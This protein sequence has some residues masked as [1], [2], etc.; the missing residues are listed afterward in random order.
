M[1]HTGGRQLL[2]PLSAKSMCACCQENLTGITWGTLTPGSFVQG[3]EAYRAEVSTPT[4]TPTDLPAM[5]LGFHQSLLVKS[6]PSIS[7][8]FYPSW[9]T[10]YAGPK[11]GDTSVWAFR[12]L[13]P[14]EARLPCP[15]GEVRTDSA[16]HVS[17]TVPNS[18]CWLPS[19]FRV[20]SK[21]HWCAKAK[22]KNTEQ[23][24]E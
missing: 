18:Y 21:S 13:E 20:E 19:T 23:R 8:L 2:L 10:A 5:Q 14:G 3:L 1:P 16:S 6:G 12:H 17:C 24:S 4:Q 22:H 7:P 9:S 15:P 11:L